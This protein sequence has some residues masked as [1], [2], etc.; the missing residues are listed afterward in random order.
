MNNGTLPTHRPRRSLLFMPGANPR[1]L[2][3]ARNLPA[4]GLIFDLEDAVAPAAKDGARSLV[5]EALDI[6]GY[7][8]RE[9]VLRINAL[10][11]PWG[12]ADLAAAA[13]LPL[14][15]VLVPKVESADEVRRVAKLLDRFK[16]PE[17]LA[18]WCMLET[19]RGILEVSRIAVA[20]PRIGVLVAGTSDLTADLHALDTP[21]RGPLMTSL[22]LLLLAARAH[23]LAAL[24]GVHLDLAD[25][26]GFVA[27]CRQGRAFGFDGKTLIHPKQIEPAN[28]AFAPT[29]PELARAKRVVA[30]VAEAQAQGTGIVLLDG[31]LIEELHAAEARR[32]LAIAKAIEEIERAIDPHPSLTASGG[33]LGRGPE[34]ATP[35]VPSVDTYGTAV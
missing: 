2:E 31:R 18:L 32:I 23:G 16:A 21:E 9:L 6:G 34:G 27:A 17:T 26:D 7:G 28:A 12:E 4:D 5:T 13:R 14:D 22:G 11:T 30:A 19:P 8:R 33:G 29:Q 24:D 15:A 35:D 20:S 3:K 10:A 25:E 1:A